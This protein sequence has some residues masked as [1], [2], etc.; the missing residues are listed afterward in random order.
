[1]NKDGRKVIIR[2]ADVSFVSKQIFHR[3]TPVK[4]IERWKKRKITLCQGNVAWEY[5]QTNS[6]CLAWGSLQARSALALF[7][8]VR[9]VGSRL[10]NQATGRRSPRPFSQRKAKNKTKTNI[11]HSKSWKKLNPSMQ[12]VTHQARRDVT[13]MLCNREVV[14]I[15]RQQVFDPSRRVWW[16]DCRK[17]K[18]GV[19]CKQ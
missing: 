10:E 7:W 6:S 18:T 1:M 4:L 16:D 13:G 12:T 19:L 17:Y 14:A 3:K 2:I 11:T 5:P 8:C 15:A 9:I